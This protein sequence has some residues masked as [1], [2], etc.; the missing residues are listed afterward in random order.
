[1]MKTLITRFSLSIL[2]PAVLAQAAVMDV[3]V[4]LL[5]GQSNAVGRG[6][7]SELPDPA[8]LYN[9][10]VMLFHSANLVSGQPARAWTTLRPASNTAGTFGPEISL[11]SRLAELYPGRRL[12]IIKHAV[13]ATNLAVDWNPGAHPRD[14]SHFGPQFA[15]FVDTVDAGLASLIAQGYTPVIRGMLWHQGER[16]SRDSSQGPVYGRNLAHFIRRVRGQFHAPSMPF[17]YAQVLPS[18][19]AGY[20]YRDQVR[21]GQLQVDQDSG[22]RWA[23]DGARLVPGDDLPMNSDNLHISAAGQI[24]LGIRF[25]DAL[26]SVVVTNAVDFNADRIIDR[27]DVGLLIDHWLQDDPTYDIAPPPFGDGIVDVE[28][29][30]VVADRLFREIPPVELIAH[31]KLDETEGSLAADSVGLYDG[32]LGGDPQWQPAQGRRNGALLLDGTDDYVSTPR[33]LDP[34]VGPFS[35]CAWVKGGA[36][37]Q[38]IVSQQGGTDWLRADPT[39]GTLRTELRT[40]GTTGR[41]AR[42]PGPALG[43]PAVIAD[44]QWHQ[45]GFVRDGDQRILYVDGREVARDAAADLEP[46]AGGLYLGAGSGLEPGRVFTGLID[47]VRIYDTALSTPEVAALAQ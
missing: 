22:H 1:M 34:A 30:I 3:D 36:P 26:G 5:G 27:E 37:G 9:E 44:G 32:V 16:D 31:W 23:T 29:L 47:E 13:G 42:P 6:A 4:F 24:E 40:P 10:S 25:A 45:V 28:D 21:E 20:D 35:V 33:V 14:N 17:I 18:A 46:A 2:W 41:A 8:V 15:T 38:V 12:A 39:D 11:G 43:G 19:L 7:I